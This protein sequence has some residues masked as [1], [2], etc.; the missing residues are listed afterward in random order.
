M[1]SSSVSNSLQGVRVFVTGGLG[2]I[3]RALLLLVC[4]RLPWHCS[5]LFVLVYLGNPLPRISHA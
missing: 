2:F 5:C 4:A 3:G 1:S